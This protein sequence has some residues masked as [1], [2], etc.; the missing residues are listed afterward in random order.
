MNLK[1]NN[2]YYDWDKTI[3]R[4]EGAGANACL[5]VGANSIGKTFGLRLRAIKKAIEKDEKFVE[6]CRYENEIPEVG[7]NYFDK[8]QSEGFFKLY[9][10]KFE[11]NTFYFR[12]N[13][14]DE[15]KII[16]FC[17]S[18]TAFQKYKKRTFGKVGY[19]I[20]DES[21]LDVL[22]KYHRYLPNE[23]EILE[24]VC[25]T[26]WRPEPNKKNSG[27]LFLLGNSVGLINPY[28]DYLGIKNPN[29]G[30]QWCK[31]KSWLFHYV[32]PRPEEEKKANVIFSI[33]GDKSK[34]S[35]FDNVFNELNDDWIEQKPSNAHFSYGIKWRDDMFGV[36]YS[37]SERMFYVNEKIPNNTNRPIFALTNNDDSVD[38]NVVKKS[39]KT[40]NYLAE[41]YYTRT[42]RYSS[43]T[44]REKFIDFLR[45]FGIK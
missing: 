37:N 45:M 39:N 17:V 10:F 42:I 24:K 41:C 14:N 2:I 43:A 26:L 35:I 20:F 7:K 38:F 1:K 19:T 15:F 23:I 3:S 12:E 6:V 36:W 21:I 30:Y 13:E 34:G 16:G 25:V 33:F 11:T 29:F 27:R 22:D 9:E 32:E 4:L 28:F 5:V 31:N 44:V 18:L 8:I 40:L